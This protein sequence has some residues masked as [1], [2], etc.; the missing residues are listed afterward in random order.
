MIS[1][2]DET[3]RQLLMRAGGI[4]PAQIE[5]S[6][7]IPNRE[8]S[9]GISR[10]T[11]NCYL[12]DIREN[13][14]LKQHGQTVEGHGSRTAARRPSVL[15]YDLTYLITAW[16]RAVEDEHRL[17]WRVLQTLLRFPALPEDMLQ[18]DLREHDLPIYTSIARPDSV[19]KSPGEFWTALENQIK[20]SLTYTVVLAT[21]RD[22]IPAGPPVMTLETRYQ[23]PETPIEQFV[24]FGGT[25][26]GSDGAPVAGA[27]IEIE[28]LGLHG[29]SD[30]EG[31]F[32]VRV[33]TPGRYVLIARFSGQIQR[34][35]V[36]IPEPQYDMT[37]PGSLPG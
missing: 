27:V 12:F 31:R 35:E 33:P 25:V 36:E 18:G 7:D 4:D 23:Q 34:R 10:P 13:L 28:G 16:T 26:R 14:H 30:D 32:R 2:L 20:P 1:E 17:L 19:L 3:I 24:W 5:I 6:F 11:I 37:L 21:D 22:A 29:F 9:S 15:R 8:W